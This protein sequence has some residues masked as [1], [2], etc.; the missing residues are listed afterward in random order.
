MRR[1]MLVSVVT[2]IAREGIQQ[3]A[4]GLWALASPYLPIGAALGIFGLATAWSWLGTVPDVILRFAAAA[5]LACAAY[6]YIFAVL[7]TCKVFWRHLWRWGVTIQAKNENIHSQSSRHMVGTNRDLVIWSEVETRI[8]GI[9]F[10]CFNRSGGPITA[11]S[12][13]CTSLK[14]NEQYECFLGGMK[15]SDT[16]G[17]PGRCEFVINMRFPRSTQDREG[18]SIEDFRNFCGDLRLTATFDG[19]KI[20]KRVR[21][22]K[23]L[24]IALE[25]AHSFARPPK[26]RPRVTRKNGA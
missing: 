8:T 2:E 19:T 12:F 10:Q 20:T 13:D 15:P 7:K 22:G 23:I 9:D 18:Y 17:I 21:A 5:G 25:R 24:A 14:T 11:V 16:N 4:F 6:I 26:D 1:S 3:I